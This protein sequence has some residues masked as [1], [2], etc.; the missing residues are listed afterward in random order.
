MAVQT[1]EKDGRYLQGFATRLAH[2]LIQKN[3]SDYELGQYI[4][5][6]LAGYYHQKW[7]GPIEFKTFE[8]WCWG[9]LHFRAGK[10][11]TLVRIFKNLQALHLAED[12]LSRVLR[13]GWSKLVLVLTVARTEQALLAWI[14]RIEDHNL[15]E[16]DL[17]YECANVKG[18]QVTGGSALPRPETPAGVIPS[19]TV[20]EPENDDGEPSSEEP[21]KPGKKRKTSRRNSTADSATPP[22]LDAPRHRVKWP[23]VFEDEESMRI[24]KD[25]LKEVEKRYPGIGN[26]RAAAL[27]ATHYF[28]SRPADTEGGA[29]VEIEYVLNA[30]EHTYGVQLAA[31]SPGEKIALERFRARRKNG[32]PTSEF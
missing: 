7:P 24:F 13:V 9:V 4:N 3:R 15:S 22:P 25:G 1:A 14:D 18:Q 8:E 31:L 17:R 12:T 6:A 2:V 23:L 26:G 27:M 28:A 10:A 21:K 5:E 20:P 30:M 32:D 11:R 16:T 29:V 19:S